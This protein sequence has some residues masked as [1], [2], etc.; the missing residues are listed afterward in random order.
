MATTA[1]GSVDKLYKVQTAASFST[2][3]GRMEQAVI[4][5]NKSSVASFNLLVGC[6]LRFCRHCSAAS[7]SAGISE[8]PAAIKAETK[9]G[10]SASR[11]L[12]AG[13][14]EKL[15]SN[16]KHF[17][18]K[19]WVVSFA[20]SNTLCNTTSL[21]Q[22]LWETAQ[23]LDN[24]DNAAQALFRARWKYSSLRYRSLRIEAMDTIV[25]MS[26]SPKVDGPTVDSSAPVR[27]V[28]SSSSSSSVPKVSSSS[29][30]LE[31]EGSSPSA[32]LSSSP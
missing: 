20:T 2:K 29:L 1:P 9:P 3:D 11:A 15:T 22:R 7:L 25:E 32:S 24:W 30:L 12:L 14:R 19:T 10:K 6:V 23:C 13:K 4:N 5:V 17:V 31:D 18:C 28:S 16:S 26:P 21:S 27:L 8:F